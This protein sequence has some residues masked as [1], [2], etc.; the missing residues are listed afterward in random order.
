MLICTRERCPW[1]TMSSSPSGTWLPSIL[2]TSRTPS[3]Q[4]TQC[5][6]VMEAL[7]DFSSPAG[8]LCPW[9]S[10]TS[11]SPRFPVP[12]SRGPG[13]CQQVS[14]LLLIPEL[15]AIHVWYWCKPRKLW[16]GIFFLFFPAWILLSQPELVVT[17]ITAQICAVITIPLTTITVTI[18]A[19]STLK[20]Y[21]APNPLTAS[22]RVCTG[23]LQYSVIE[24]T[25]VFAHLYIQMGS[26]Y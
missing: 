24:P 5:E 19:T 9:V 15:W 6:L 21:N 26:L 11:P 14:P 1:P 18:I 16:F 25:I 17:D 4:R 3:Q 22:P 12:P 7:Q 2:A 8:A 20:D 23:A 13:S 10:S